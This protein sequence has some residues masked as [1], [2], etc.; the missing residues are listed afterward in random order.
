MTQASMDFS[1]KIIAVAEQIESG[2]AQVVTGEWSFYTLVADALTTLVDEPKPTAGID[3]TFLSVKHNWSL[4][5]FGPGDRTKGVLAHI[6]KE[7]QEIE[8]NPDD[9]SEWA[10]LI[11]LAFDGFARRGFTAKQIVEA[12]RN[13]QLLN[14]TRHWPD[15]RTQPKDGPIEH[16]REPGI[17][18]S[19]DN[20]HIVDCDEP[21]KFIYRN[22]Q[23]KTAVRKV[24][25]IGDWFWPAGEGEAAE[26][27]AYLT[28]RHY[29]EAF[30]YEEPTTVEVQRGIKLPSIFAAVL[31]KAGH[32]DLTITL[33]N[34]EAEAEAMLGGG[35]NG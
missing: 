14:Q 17:V 18:K 25:P 33:H 7:L 20:P 28:L 2:L 23:N 30:G 10:D 19:V 16:I 6:R 1:P 27:S 29:F 12:I 4:E 21:L 22:W 8:N 34:T 24:K 11:L 35:D 32:K 15:W 26:R 13:K 9:P 31:R 3:T 5:T